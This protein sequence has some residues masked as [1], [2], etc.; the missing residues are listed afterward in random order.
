MFGNVEQTFLEKPPPLQTFVSTLKSAIADKSPLADHNGKIVEQQQVD[1]KDSVRE[2]IEQKSR[3]KKTPSTVICELST[4]TE[5]NNQR[6]KG[7]HYVGTNVCVSSIPEKHIP[8]DI[9]IKTQD[10]FSHV[11]EEKI[12]RVSKP[13]KQIVASP[14]VKK[15][16]VINIHRRRSTTDIIR[17]NEIKISAQKESILQYQPSADRVDIS[18]TVLPEQI[19]NQ[20]RSLNILNL[21][22][23][24]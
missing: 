3:K 8:G 23:K 6:K 5:M 21:K 24:K 12:D 11:E 2:K 20:R 9:P 1:P 4:S 18:Y 16:D 17:K 14:D 22:R 15:K 10:K 7:S 13:K 19:R